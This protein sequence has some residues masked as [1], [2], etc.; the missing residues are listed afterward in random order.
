VGS[1]AQAQ[2]FELEKMSRKKSKTSQSRGKPR[3]GAPADRKR[4]DR[5]PS[6]SDTTHQPGPQPFLSA[7]GM[8][9]VIESVV[10]AFVLAFLFRTFEAEAFVIPTGS[11]APTLM[12]RHKDVVCPEC[13][14]RFRVSASDEI[15]SKTNRPTGSEVLSGTCPMC[16]Y[17][18]DVRARNPEGEAHRSYKGDRILVSKFAYRFGDPHRW[19]VAVFKYPG[20]AKTNFIKRIVGLPEE[21]IAISH[22]DLFVKRA[23]EE[24]FLRFDA[25]SYR[26][27]NTP[28][29]LGQFDI[30]RKPPAKIKAMLQPVYDNDRVL[31]KIIEAG[32]PA[33]WS[34]AARSDLAEGWTT[35]ED[36]RSFQTEGKAAGDVW[37]TYRHIVPSYEDW[38]FL[39]RGEMPPGNPEP[40]P[41]FIT[42][43]SAYNTDVTSYGGYSRSSH[44]VWYEGNGY[45]SDGGRFEADR[46]PAPDHTMLGRHWVGDLAVECTMEVTSSSGEALF[47]LVEG[48][49]VFQCRIDLATGK[50]TLG[51]DASEAYRPTATTSVRGPGTYRIM[52]SNID[53]RLLLWVSDKPSWINPKV[54]RFDTETAYSPLGNTRPRGDDRERPVRIGSRGA[55]LRISHLKIYR[56]IYYIAQRL[57]PGAGNSAA[58]TDYDSA[59]W[60][61]ANR[62]EVARVLSNPQEW[63]FFRSARQIVFPLG[64]GQFLALD[65]DYGRP[66]ASRLWASDD[67]ARYVSRELFG[68]AAMADLVDSPAQRWTSEDV[69]HALSDP[70]EWLFFKAARVVAF[71]LREDQFLVLG[72]NS[73]E[74]KDSRL[75]N[76]ERLES[77]E[78]LPYYVRRELLMG[79][80]LFIYWPHSLDKIPYTDIPIRFLPNL[81][82]MHFVR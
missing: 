17:T 9:E 6:P 73:A 10:I 14:Y 65:H 4:K 55:G 74:S 64:D 50:A 49:R 80:A 77:G 37:I 46:P 61:C 75:W 21:T 20:E 71:P 51:I 63:A 43:F 1:L 26:D 2:T 29:D 47:E 32:W 45:D 70:G 66:E 11:M 19:D 34:P 28:I 35:S 24:D 42:D 8:R 62:S 72:D 60:T 18:M 41:Q 59:P 22:G 12:G 16:R 25:S 38:R 5:T 52:F 13:G 76:G 54:V 31:P 44:N 36:Y 81:A 40:K 58:I 48:G 56:D 39:K 53:D 68:G 57:V 23:A 33:R 69:A 3:A 27:G 82:R 79:K 30:A 15:N 67:F 78:P 7:A